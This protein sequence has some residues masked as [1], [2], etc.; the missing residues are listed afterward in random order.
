MSSLDW[1]STEFIFAEYHFTYPN[2][3]ANRNTYSHK[4][5]YITKHFIMSKHKL[6]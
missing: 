2:E 4:K 1:E 5:S 6:T 3:K